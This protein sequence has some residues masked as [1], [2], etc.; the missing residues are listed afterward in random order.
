MTGRCA[1]NALEAGDLWLESSLFS[2]LLA[3]NRSQHRRSMHF[4]RLMQASIPLPVAFLLDLRRAL[5]ILRR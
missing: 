1:Q 5:G 3:K 4:T 2:R